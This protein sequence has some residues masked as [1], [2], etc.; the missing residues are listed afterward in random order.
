MFAHRSLRSSPGMPAVCVTWVSRQGYRSRQ[1]ILE[2]LVLFPTQADSFCILAREHPH[3][4]PD[5]VAWAELVHEPAYAVGVI[6][7][8]AR[9]G[10]KLVEIQ[11]P[12]TCDR[13]LQGAMLNLAIAVWDIV[14][15]DIDEPRTFLALH[16]ALE[17]P[18]SLFGFAHR[19][20]RSSPGMPAVCGHYPTNYGGCQRLNRIDPWA[21]P[22]YGLCMTDEQALL[23]EIDT[24]LRQR[25][26]AETTFGRLAVNDGK[27]VGR[28]RDGGTLTVATL[29]RVREYIAENVA[30]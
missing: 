8:M 2:T 26:I 28:L 27:F 4:Q 23:R 18:A 6:G 24:Y 7:F 29:R 16:G 17:F 14:R 5:V 15:I 21:H 9:H 12:R 30:P 19:S 13:F 20:L 22:H 11:R 3:P 10:C 25:M 1:R